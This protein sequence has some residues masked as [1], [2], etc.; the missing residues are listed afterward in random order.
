MMRDLGLL[1]IAALLAMAAPGAASGYEIATTDN[2]EQYLLH[3]DVRLVPFNL[4]LHGEEGVETPL[5]EEAL[6]RAFEAWGEVPEA[7]VLFFQDFSEADRAA[8]ADSRNVLFWTEGGWK[9]DATVIALTSI[10]YYPDTGIIA[11]ADIDFNG[12]DYVWTVS[13]DV[14]R[15]DVQAIATHEIGHVVGLDHSEEDTAAMYAYY[16]VTPAGVGETRQRVLSGDDKAAISFLYPCE[17][18]RVVEGDRSVVGMEAECAEAFFDWPEYADEGGPHTA[19]CAVSAGRAGLWVVGLLAL[20]LAV[21]RRGAAARLPLLL[22]GMVVVLAPSQSELLANITPWAE[23]D[24]TAALADGVARAEVTSVE[25]LWSEDGHVH[26][27]V[28]LRVEEWLAGD[29]PEH[30]L[31]ER[32][33]G[34]N[35]ELGTYVPG[36]PRFEIG[37]DLILLLADRHDGSPGLVGMSHGFVE[38]VE[39]DGTV[40]ARRTPGAGASVE[41]YPLE[42]LQG[43]L[44]AR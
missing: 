35:A 20:G 38:V 26:S 30:L 2:E 34:V 16:D 23:L 24:R 31:L 14:V 11:D 41:W 1:W 33:S 10:N 43:R 44:R 19:T 37:Q 8:Q 15:I 36:D 27:L 28:E 13:D 12:V 9:H 22:W 17:A 5:L 39:V 40:V 21:W 42:A 4:Q 32:P 6:I 3:W 25:P 29:G 7:G 18:L